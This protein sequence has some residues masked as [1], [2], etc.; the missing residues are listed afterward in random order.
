MKK[1][2][3]VA[4]TQFSGWGCLAVED[5]MK[6]IL[7]IVKEVKDKNCYPGLK[8]RKAF[9]ACT[10]PMRLLL[11]ESSRKPNSQK[12]ILLIPITKTNMEGW[13]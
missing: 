1:G 5:T 4:F 10:F 11:V 13:V 6:L 3:S 12:G 2:P 7:G 8:N 9:P